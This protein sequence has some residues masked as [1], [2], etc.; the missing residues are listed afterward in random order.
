[1]DKPDPSQTGRKVSKRN[2]QWEML[3]GEIKSHVS[4]AGASQ[5]VKE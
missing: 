3:V 1:M 5:P 2:S 4:P